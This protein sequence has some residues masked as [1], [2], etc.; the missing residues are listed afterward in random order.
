MEKGVDISHQNAEHA[1]LSLALVSSSTK[2]RRAELSVLRQN[3]LDYGKAA[4]YSDEPGLTLGLG[5]TEDSCPDVIA[6]L[7]RTYPFY[8]DR[9][10]RRAVQ[11]CLE[12]LL[13][14]P[15]YAGS[16]PLLFKAFNREASKHGLAPSNAFV[17]VE[18][19][20]IFLQHCFGTQ[21][22]WNSYGKDLVVSHAQILEVCCSSGVRPGVKQSALVVTRR[23]LRKV[24]GSN[25]GGDATV[26]SVVTLLATRS[27]PL[28]FRS[29]V[30]LGVVAGVCAR[31]PSKRPILEHQKGHYYSFYTREIIASRFK[32]PKHVVIGLNDFF[33]NFTTIDDLSQDVVPAMEKALLRAPEVI[34]DDLISPLVKSLSLAIDLTQLLSEHL[35]K[36]LLSNIKSQNVAIRNGAMSAFTVLISRCK[37]ETYLERITDDIL[38]PLSTSKLAGAEQRTLHARMLTLLPWQSSRTETICT[39]LAA[40]ITKEPNEGALGTETAA[41]TQQYSL[42]ATSGFEIGSKA[43]T[44]ITDVFCNGLS[45]K[46]AAT[47]KTWALRVGDLLWLLKGQ[48]GDSPET[49]QLVEALV[50]Q[51]LQ[52]FDEAALSPQ[53]AAQSG[54]AVAAY[55]VT[56]LW[57]DLLSMVKDDA[58]EAAI[59]KAKVYDRVLT[60]SPKSSILLNHR[61]YTKLSAKEDYTWLIRALVACSGDLANV[62]STSAAGDAWVQVFLYLISATDIPSDIQ[63]HAIAALTQVYLTDPAAVAGAVVQGLWS[64]LRSVEMGNKDTAAAAVQ[65]GNTRLYTAVRSICPPPRMRQPGIGDV[66]I[67]VLQ[68]QLINML[69][70]CRPEILPR[71]NWIEMCLRMGQDPGAVVRA[72]AVQCVKKVDHFLIVDGSTTFSTMVQLAA[73]NTAAEL[74]F[75][76]P[77]IITPLLLERIE[78]DLVADRVKAF[79]PT[80][81]AIARTPEGTVCVDVLSTKVQHRALDKNTKDYDTMKWEEE[82]R[83]QL[84]QKKGQERK[85]TAEEKAKVNAQLIKEAGIRSKVL[86]LERR[87]KRGL[88]FINSLATGPPTE[89]DM[90]MGPCLKALLEV[91]T[92][93]ARLL[94]GNAADESYLSCS[95]LVSPRLGSLRRFVG[96]ATLRGLGSSH[97]PSHLE[98]EPLGGMSMT[99]ARTDAC[100]NMFL[101]LVTRI[102][103]RL[104]FA[105]EQRPF[106]SVSLGYLLPLA[107]IVIQKGGVGHSGADEVDEQVT[108]ALE[109]LSF[110]TDACKHLNIP[111]HVSAT[112]LAYRLADSH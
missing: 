107:F 66:D 108:L 4:W 8:H 104:R 90:W 35:L 43:K 11:E 95:N 46:R 69:V 70:L 71:V 15:S 30:F 73:H 48:V 28:G 62:G 85:L 2:W 53:A 26:D 49:V 93:G 86:E 31:L 65:T 97:L 7:F 102:L 52:I 80:D 55:V 79:G 33:A 77:D 27:Q 25:S 96:V 14:N 59:H 41:L 23:A 82:V 9:A 13:V 34:L 17:L 75:V 12:V 5:V 3:L 57:N 60:P 37:D 88:G 54:L 111:C 45:D 98:Q 36:P 83:T 18:W 92:A 103:Y 72:K 6:I 56:A 105:S 39:S 1:S 91:I 87:L 61:I 42:I 99:I 51:A 58:V 32:V 106:D 21:E 38:L 101:D 19:G 84:A 76:A 16:V 89:A 81:I 10:S 109:F 64:W 44:S 74:A 112:L 94:V 22:P 100:A 63:K 67:D 40:I 29:A 47:R 68:A 24:L 50:P 78:R 110:H 20:S